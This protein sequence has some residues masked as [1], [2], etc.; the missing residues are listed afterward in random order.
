[1]K[2]IAVLT[3]VFAAGVAFGIQTP[4]GFHCQSGDTSVVLHWDRN[5]DANLAGYRVYRAVTNVAGPYTLVNSSLL[6]GPGKPSGPPGS[7][8]RHRKRSKLL[9]GRLRASLV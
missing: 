6:S 3:I 8:G 9:E 5:T 2:K 1:M 4:I 7:S